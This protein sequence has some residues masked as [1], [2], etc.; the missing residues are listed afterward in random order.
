M[1]KTTSYRQCTLYK[2]CGKEARK[3]MVSHIPETFAQ[4]GNVLKL[5]QE[6]STWDDGWIVETVSVR[7]EDADLPN[8]R[9]AIKQHRK[10]TGDAL[11]KIA[12]K[13]DE[14]DR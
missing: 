10:A 14:G 6:D 5:K 11:P 8:S 3:V 13:T 9:K 1:S 2:P 4:V 12:A 7:I